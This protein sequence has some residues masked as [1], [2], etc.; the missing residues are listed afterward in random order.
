MFPLHT[1]SWISSAPSSPA[2]ASGLKVAANIE[3]DVGTRVAVEFEGFD[4]MTAQIMWRHADE[5]GLSLPV[6]S[7]ELF[8]A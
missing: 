8:D 2:S 7:L 1:E 4:V 5:I 6:E 3:A